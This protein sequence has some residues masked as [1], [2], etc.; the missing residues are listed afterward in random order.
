MKRTPN[1]ASE[2]ETLLVALGR[3]EL[4]VRQKLSHGNLWLFGGWGGNAPA[5]LSDLWRYVP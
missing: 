2:R 1:V 4:G 5:D 3:F